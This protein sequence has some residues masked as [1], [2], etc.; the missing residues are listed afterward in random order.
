VAT[1]AGREALKGGKERVRELFEE[2]IEDESL[3]LKQRFGIPIKD[4][5][6]EASSLN[7]TR[8]SNSADRSFC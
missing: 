5:S 3:P 4:V 8:F 7:T 2:L 1:G 6:G